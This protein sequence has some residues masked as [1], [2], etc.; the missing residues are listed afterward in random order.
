MP[1]TDAAC[2]GARP[3]AKAYKKA[4]GQGLYL[5]VLPTGG[6]K[7]PVLKDLDKFVF[8]DTT[9]DEGLVRE[10]A[11]G[12]FLDTKRNAIFIGGTVEPIHGQSGPAWR[13]CASEPSGGA[14]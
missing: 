6:A 9:V 2:K 1:L 3:Q 8:A 11:I 13:T 14:L 5:H 4:D 10:L 12:S 7:F